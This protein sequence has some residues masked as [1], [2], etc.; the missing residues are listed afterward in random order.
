V[1][2][3]HQAGGC[4][5]YVFLLESDMALVRQS[6]SFMCI[7]VRLVA[8]GGFAGGG[9]L[10]VQVGVLLVYARNRF[11]HSPDAC[12]QCVLQNVVICISDA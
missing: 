7:H 12:R 4:V 9:H 1:L 8:C 6:T 11:A 3:C 10:L 5:L 2:C